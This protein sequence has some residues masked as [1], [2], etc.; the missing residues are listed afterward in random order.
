[1]SAVS[2]K[3]FAATAAACLLF[4]SCVSQPKNAPPEEFAEEPFVYETGALAVSEFSE[5]WAY[6]ISGRETALLPDLPVTDIGYFGAEVDSYGNLVYVPQREKIASFAGRVHLVVTCPGYGLTHFMLDPASPGRNALVSQL[7]KASAAFDGLQIDFENVL[8]RD[9]DLFLSFLKQLRADLPAD[10]MLTVALPARERVYDNDRYD[11]AA[12]APVVDRLLVM[13]YDEHWSTSKP[14]PIASMDWCRRVAL[15]AQSQVPPE[16]L[17]MLAPFYGRTWGSENTFRAFFHSG[18]ERIKNENAVQEIN[19]ENGIPYFS[20][21][22]PITVNV[23]YEDAVSLTT[24]LS[25]YSGMNVMRT[26]FWCLGQEDP[27]IWQF[28]KLAN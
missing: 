4:F 27:A 2:F 3:F 1:M 25:L 28:I 14:G 11:Y 16:K 8:A 7:V 20:Y 5:V 12:I 17:V 9:G 6:L 23:Y 24:R 10:K 15:H 22:I 21:E 13:A 18:I 19:R 26:G